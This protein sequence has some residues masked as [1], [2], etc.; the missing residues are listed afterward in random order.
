M[1]PRGL[2]ALPFPWRLRGLGDRKRDNKR[3]TSGVAFM[4]KGACDA[5]P[6]GNRSSRRAPGR[7]RRE[8][9]ERPDYHVFEFDDIGEQHHPADHDD[10]GRHHYDDLW[11]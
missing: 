3:W 8:R 2:R 11:W 5:T 1:D 7:M 6:G 9:R 4:V 10:H